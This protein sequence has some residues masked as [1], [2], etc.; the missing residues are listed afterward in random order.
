MNALAFTTYVPGKPLTWDTAALTDRLID[1]YFE[2]VGECD[3]KLAHCTT[4][5][6]IK[7]AAGQGKLATFLAIEGGHVL[8]GRAE[9]VERFHSRGVRLMTLTHFL[10]NEIADGTTSPY[11]PHNGLSAFGREVVREMERVGMLVDVAHSTQKAMA[12]VLAAATRPVI[13]SH[14]ALRR[15]RDIERNLT[16]DQVRAIAQT[17]GLIGIIFFWSY[18]GSSGRSIAA[19]ARQCRDVADLVGPQHLCIGTDL[20]GCT[21][22]PPGFVDASDWPQV[23]QA[24]IDEG[25]TDAEIRGILGDNFLRCFRKVCG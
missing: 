20:D 12:D 21:F 17:G 24:L 4:A 2:I 5:A 1:R 19:V 10:S 25:F 14:G 3:G 15:Y 16:G 8:M 23:T 7:A 9:N 11:R 13:Y 22:T 18:L 6:Q